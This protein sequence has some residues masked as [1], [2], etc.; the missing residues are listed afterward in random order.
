MFEVPALCDACVTPTSA[1]DTYHGNIIDD[2]KLR[3]TKVGWP[4]VAC[5]SCKFHENLS[6]EG[7]GLNCTDE[8][9]LHDLKCI[10]PRLEW[11]LINIK[12]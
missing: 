11:L 12:K 9:E 3:S 10:V 6:R 5:H 4:L 8:V 2:R 7:S 1:I